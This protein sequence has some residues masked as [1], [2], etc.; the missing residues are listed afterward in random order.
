MVRVARGGLDFASEK[1][2]I[3]VRDEEFAIERNRRPAGALHESAVNG[4]AF[5]G[6]LFADAVDLRD[7]D[8]PAV[9][10]FQRRDACVRWQRLACKGKLTFGEAGESHADHAT[11]HALL[12]T[13]PG[14]FGDAAF[15]LEP[16]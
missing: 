5:D 1:E 3:L 8:Y 14:F 15:V 11:Q 4:D 16:T 7:G 2:G 10:I 9:I 12:E 6:A 13:I